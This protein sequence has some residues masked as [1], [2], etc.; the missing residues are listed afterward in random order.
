MDIE[1][2]K[3]HFDIEW[4]V[5]ISDLR[6]LKGFL[7]GYMEVSNEK[8]KKLLEDE[9][10]ESEEKW[11]YLYVSYS[12]RSS[13]MKLPLKQKMR[14]QI[15]VRPF[16]KYAVYVKADLMID[17]NWANRT[18]SFEYDR[19]ISKISYVISLPARKF[20]LLTSIYWFT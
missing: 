18:A 11:A 20:F 8:Q 7:I 13:N 19:V 6:R 5:D 15:E 10:Y 16:R 12:Q 9:E 4:D 14:G 3:G 1:V 2:K 17:T